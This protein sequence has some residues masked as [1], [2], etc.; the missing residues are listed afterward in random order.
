MQSQQGEITDFSGIQV[1][2]IEAQR[3]Q[4]I[5]A[6]EYVNL[7]LAAQQDLDRLTSPVLRFEHNLSASSA[8]RAYLLGEVS[9]M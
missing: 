3:E 6:I 9:I 4:R 7:V 2:I 5:H 1:T 8:R